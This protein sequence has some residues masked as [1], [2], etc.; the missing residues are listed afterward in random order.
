M[1]TPLD[2]SQ[3]PPE[4]QGLPPELVQQLMA[5]GQG[6]APPT[7]QG[8]EQSPDETPED[9]IDLTDIYEAIHAGAMLCKGSK[10]GGE[11]QQAAAGV[12]D[13]IGSVL[14]LTATGPAAPAPNQGG[15]GGSASGS[16]E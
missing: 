16:G 11:F 10:T 1:G 6:G 5:E 14:E 15:G 2:P 8:P 12:K 3:L 9:H 4:L 7:E 13:L